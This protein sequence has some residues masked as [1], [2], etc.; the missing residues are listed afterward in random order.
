M[1]AKNG[2]NAASNA[3]LYNCRSV[4]AVPK[5]ANKKKISRVTRS[6]CALGRLRRLKLFVVAVTTEIVV[7]SKIALHHLQIP[8][9]IGLMV[10]SSR[11]AMEK[12]RGSMEL[13]SR[14]RRR[15]LSMQDH[16]WT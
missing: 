6:R 2:Q 13:A 9:G 14:K 5:T 3:M 12:A 4:A 15:S 10:S 8:G 1:P 11:P 7:T 16:S